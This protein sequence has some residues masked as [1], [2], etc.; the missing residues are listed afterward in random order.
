MAKYDFFISY[1]SKDKDVAKKIVGAI[2]STQHSC[3]I[4]PRNIPAGTPY[5]RAI[6]QG[7][8]DSNI[9]LVLITD[10]SI[11]S[12]DV[13]NEVDNAHATKKKIIPVRLTDT[14]L[15]PELN[16][17]LSRNQWIDLSSK[18]PEKIIKL[19]GLVPPSVTLTDNSDSGK[20]GPSFWEKY[21]SAIIIASAI[22][23]LSLIAL[24]CWKWL[25]ISISNNIEN[26]ISENTSL[27]LESI[28]NSHSD[29]KG[30]ITDSLPVN[31]TTQQK[32]IQYVDSITPTNKKFKDLVAKAE[33]NYRLK[34]FDKAL[35]LFIQIAE[36]YNSNYA[37]IVGD[38][39]EKGEGTVASSSIAIEWY[40]KAADDGNLDAQLKVGHLL[41]S[42]GN[43]LE[44]AQYCLQAESYYLKHGNIWN[45]QAKY[46]NDLGLVYYNGFGAT[47]PDKR[48][49]KNYFLESAKAGN[50]TAQSNLENLY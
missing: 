31:D 39:Y 32:F 27:P 47:N 30:Q 10:N 15:P 42:E 26:K 49:A 35:P 40:K 6:M 50:I 46:L 23:V 13:L 34:N 22:A 28:V 37:C 45:I 14:P 1:S 9:F 25:P 43:Y 3:W 41:L 24:V 5:A 36:D 2:E 11:K 18:N 4:A 17:Y 7:I 48:K 33:S 8:H 29:L 21:K 16:Y 44:G 19:L 12:E 20:K 38:M